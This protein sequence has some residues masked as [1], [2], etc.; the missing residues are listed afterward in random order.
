MV[1]SRGVWS[2]GLH[3]EGQLVAGDARR[4]IGVVYPNGLVLLVVLLQRVQHLPLHAGGDAFR[5][6]QV[7]D[8]R[9]T[10]AEDGGLIGSRHVAAA[11]VLGA[12]NGPAAR[13]EHH[14]ESG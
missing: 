11:P 6:V 3:A 14:H 1:D 9:L 10:V 7:E 12:A 4:Q 2:V 13:V 8:R 5:S